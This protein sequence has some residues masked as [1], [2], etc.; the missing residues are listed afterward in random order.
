MTGGEKEF[1]AARPPAAGRCTGYWLKWALNPSWSKV[2]K[3]P[4]NCINARGETVAEKPAFRS[5]FKKR[6]CLILADG[7]YESKGKPGKK[8]PWHFHLPGDSPFAFAGLWEGWRPEERKPVETCTIVTTAA[9]EFS[10]KYHDRMPVIVDPGDYDRWLEPMTPTDRLLPLLD[11]R[12]VAG[13]EVVAVN[14]AVNN[15]RNDGPDLLSPA[16]IPSA[17]QR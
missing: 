4:S 11:S 7:W 13:M 5:A 14:S 9:N 6:R 1:L 10:A 17:G 12:P 8:Q 3:I 16:T 15:R 2:P